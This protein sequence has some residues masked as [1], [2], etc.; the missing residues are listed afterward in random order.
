VKTSSRDQFDALSSHALNV[1]RALAALAPLV[2]RTRLHSLNARVAALQLGTDGA[3]FGVVARSLAEVGDELAELAIQVEACRADVIN[4]LARCARAECW[5]DVSRRGLGTG[6]G[7]DPTADPLPMPTATVWSAARD[8]APPLEA[9]LWSAILSYRRDMVLAVATLAE[10]VRDLLRLTGAVERV[11]ERHGFFIGTNALVEAS[12]LG[13]DG[14]G[15]TTLAVVLRDLTVD[16]RA[17]VRVAKTE[18]AALVELTG[19][20]VNHD[21]TAAIRDAVALAGSGTEGG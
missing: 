2:S 4:A 5:L 3:A 9:A 21:V 7:A 17:G 11:A 15:V 10:R 18:A 14:E 8:V 20:L 19:V 13:R 1:G 12:R 6:A 16:I